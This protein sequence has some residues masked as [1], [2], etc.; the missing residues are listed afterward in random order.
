MIKS[1]DK[2][3]DYGIQLDKFVTNE[4][5]YDNYFNG[6]LKKIFTTP[7]V[8]TSACSRMALGLLF[9][10]Y[11]VLVLMKV[12]NKKIDIKIITDSKKLTEKLYKEGVS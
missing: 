5:L 1:L 2:A 3:T 10:I 9:G 4:S 11:F 6:V 8:W 12:V 7:R